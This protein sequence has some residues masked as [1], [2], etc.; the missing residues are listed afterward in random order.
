[1]LKVKRPSLRLSLKG[2]YSQLELGTT[3]NVT[4]V[5]PTIAAADYPIRMIERSKFG[6]KDIRTII[7]C[8]LGETQ[9]DEKIGAAIRKI[10]YMANKALIDKLL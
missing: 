2:A 7:Y 5:R 10:G 3:V 8:G 4:M 1:M 9:V 6:I